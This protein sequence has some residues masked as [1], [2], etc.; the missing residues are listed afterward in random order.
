[1]RRNS[2]LAGNFR[3]PPL[4]ERPIYPEI[5]NYFSDLCHA[6]AAIPEAGIRECGMPEQGS[7]VPEEGNN[8][9]DFDRTGHTGWRCHGWSLPCDCGNNAV[10]DA[11]SAGLSDQTVDD[12]VRP[13][14]RRIAAQMM[15]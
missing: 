6:D 8:C 7:F 11:A 12:L 1:L 2:L 15:N 13:C 10:V 9:P 3:L 5:L 14:A 4:G